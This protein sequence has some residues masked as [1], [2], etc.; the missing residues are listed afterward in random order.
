[1]AASESKKGVHDTEP[2]KDVVDVS[3]YPDRPYSEA[4][5]KEHK[6]Y[7]EGLGHKVGKADAED[8]TVS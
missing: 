3:A 7:L 2:I 5:T 1:M 6:A 8:P 4:V